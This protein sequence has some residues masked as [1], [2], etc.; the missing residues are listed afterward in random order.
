M[1]LQIASKK[2]TSC[3]LPLIEVLEDKNKKVKKK[4]ER[5]N[6]PLE[7]VFGFSILGYCRNMADCGRGPTL[8]ADIKRDQ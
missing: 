1:R 7:L 3:Q 4:K 8:S 5:M 6:G 2:K